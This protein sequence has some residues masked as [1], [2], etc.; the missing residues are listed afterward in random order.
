MPIRVAVV[1]AAGFFGR[2]LCKVLSDNGEAVTAVTRESYAADRGAAYDVVVNA[3]MPS[4][5][6]WAKQHPE[7]DFVE[8]VQ[9]TSD[10]LT[11]WR[12]ERF[13]QISSLSARCERHT[14]YGRHKAAAEVLCERPDCF[15]VRLTSLYGDG[16]SKGAL[17]DIR[18]GGPVYV[19]GDSRYAFTHVSFAAGFVAAACRRTDLTGVREVGAKNTVTL[20]EVARVM[21]KAIQFSGPVE[22]QQVEG[23][24]DEY[25]DAREVLT[26][27]TR[28]P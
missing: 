22:L 4:K 3:A 16:M 15:T 10:L 17:V 20:Q 13:I 25:P 21:K 5:R 1:G 9:K 2:A 24:A 8:T 12:F 18:N 23:P 19:D 7:L 27:V 6:F 11:G 26:F 14:V 28:M